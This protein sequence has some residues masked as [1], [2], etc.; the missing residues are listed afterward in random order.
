[1]QTKKVITIEIEEEWYLQ[2]LNRGETAAVVLQELMALYPLKVER[3][4]NIDGEGIEVVR[5]YDCASKPALL[6]STFYSVTCECGS[7]TET[8]VTRRDA[9]ELWNEQN[10]D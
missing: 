7:S 9:I 2:A 3:V 5:C 8:T 6:L 4:D 10:K 1:M